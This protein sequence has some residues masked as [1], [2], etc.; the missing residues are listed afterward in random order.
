MMVEKVNV[1]TERGLLSLYYRALVPPHQ[2]QLFACSVNHTALD[3]LILR[4]FGCLK[5]AVRNRCVKHMVDYLWFA[6]GI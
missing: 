6:C 1:G 4:V 2:S 3:V 5:V